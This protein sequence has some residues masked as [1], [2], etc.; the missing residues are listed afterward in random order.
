[1]PNKRSMGN[2]AS[3]KYKEEY[4]DVAIDF[5]S[6]G[7]STHELCAKLKIG[8]TTFYDWQAVHEEFRDAV[9][10]G[11][12]NGIAY[13]LEYGRQNME[14][15]EFNESAFSNY[16]GRVYGIT[17]QKRSRV[18]LRAGSLGESFSKLL[19]A[20]ANA[21][22]STK[23]TKELSGVLMDGVSISEHTELT[24]KL[25]ALEEKMNEKK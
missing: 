1:M 8:Q 24:N 21:Q 18:D 20:V 19:D 7:K 6:E 3:S 12:E 4:V 23:E 16:L 10:I 14:N 11:L 13:W 17:K 2:R 9:D 22:V 25:K 15:P 5:L